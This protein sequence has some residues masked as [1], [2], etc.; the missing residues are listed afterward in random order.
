MSIDPEPIQSFDA[1]LNDKSY[2]VSSNNAAPLPSTSYNPFIYGNDVD[3]V[4][5]AT[6]VAMVRFFNSP[7]ILGNF[8]EHTRT[9]RLHP[10]AVVAFQYSSFV[11]SRPVKSAF[12]IRLAKTQAVEFFAEWS[13]CP[14]NV[15]FLRV[16]TGE[17]EPFDRSRR[18]SL[19]GVYDPALIGDKPKWYSR[20]LTS[21]PFN[22]VEE[23]STL[24][25]AL[26]HV[27]HTPSDETGSDS[28]EE[29][30]NADYSSL[31]DFV[32]E[33]R[34]SE[35]CGEIRGKTSPRS[36]LHPR[37]FSGAKMYPENQEKTACV[38]YSTVYSP[39]E[40]LQIPD[41]SAKATSPNHSGNESSQSMSESSISSGSTSLANSRLNSPSEETPEIGT[42]LSALVPDLDS[43]SSS[44]T[45]TPVAKFFPK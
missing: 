35:I 41:G 15:A 9:L 39:P 24:G 21:I 44:A 32:S 36:F 27:E 8:N 30:P 26:N 17:F 13:L 11:R 2:L 12:I 10:R 38:E 19:S 14:D 22:I 28:E 1:M 5:I 20:N 4:D 45:I 25:A 3:S 40:E 37:R 18:V 34:N 16:Q 23:K 42:D 6:R 31:S 7:N 43:K 33:M 29:N